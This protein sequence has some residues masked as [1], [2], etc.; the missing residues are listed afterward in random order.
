[1]T[2]KI[3]FY[4][5]LRDLAGA[6]ELELSLPEGTTVEALLDKLYTLHPRLAEWDNRV[7]LAADLDYVERTHVIQAGEVISVMPPVQGG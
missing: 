4:S 6:A 5:V 7:L 3:E 1:M 2:T